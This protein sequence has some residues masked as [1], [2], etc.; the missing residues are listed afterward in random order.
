VVAVL[1]SCAAQLFVASEGALLPSI[2][3]GE[4]LMVANSALSVAT[5]AVRLVGPP[6]GGLMYALLGLTASVLVDSASFLVSGL[7][8]LAIRMPAAEAQ[9]EPDDDGADSARS[10]FLREL[11]EGVRGIVGNRVFEALCLVLAAVMVTQGRLETLLVPFVG[12]AARAGRAIGESGGAAGGCGR[13]RGGQAL[14]RRAGVGV[15]VGVGRLAA[16]RRLGVDDTRVGVAPRWV[17]AARLRGADGTLVAH[18]PQ[19]VARRAATVPKCRCGCIR[20]PR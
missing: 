18:V 2:V 5:S 1:E 11:V 4:R 13:R 14:G 16:G 9:A 20:A 17:A 15:G 12:G 7:V 8:F 3:S 19:L 10:S 6:L